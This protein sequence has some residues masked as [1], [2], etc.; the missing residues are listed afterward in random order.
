M[1]QQEARREIVKRVCEHGARKPFREIVLR[2]RADPRLAR[3]NTPSEEVHYRVERAVVALSSTLSHRLDA[4]DG[5]H[6]PL[7]SKQIVHGDQQYAL[8]TGSDLLRISD[9]F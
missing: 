9:A 7:V 2:P 4:Q 3:L 1:N 6:M 8:R 5:D